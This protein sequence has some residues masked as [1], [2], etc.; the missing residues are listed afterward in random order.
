MH[1]IIT[2]NSNKYKN[3]VT[4]LDLYTGLSTKYMDMIDMLKNL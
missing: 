1:Q 3:M 2:N 4:E